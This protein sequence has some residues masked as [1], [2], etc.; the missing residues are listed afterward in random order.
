MHLTG[1]RGFERPDYAST[2]TTLAH[3]SAHTARRYTDHL[4]WHARRRPVSLV[5]AAGLAH[6]ARLGRRSA[7]AGRRISGSLPRACA[8]RPAPGRAMV[9]SQTLGTLA[10]RRVHVLLG[11]G[12]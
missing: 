11:H 10:R 3:V 9:V 12:Y 1:A 7:E 2:N 8:D 5:G 6:D 4:S